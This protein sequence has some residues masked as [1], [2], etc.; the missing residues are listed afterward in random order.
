MYPYS[1]SETPW[2]VTNVADC[3]RLL[4]IVLFKKLKGHE[5]VFFFSQLPRFICSYIQILGHQFFN[6]R[7]EIAQYLMNFAFCVDAPDLF[8]FA[9]RGGRPFS[10]GDLFD[11]D[12]L[13]KE[14]LPYKRR[15]CR[16]LI[17]LISGRLKVRIIQFIFLLLFFIYLF[18]LGASTETADG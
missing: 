13:I 5:V 18:L 15:F 12:K 1:P 17:P 11:W 6:P 8:Y 9:C 2:D 16:F 14:L 10:C 4:N 3:R 7:P